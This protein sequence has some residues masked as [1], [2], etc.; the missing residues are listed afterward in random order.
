MY[1]FKAT[2]SKSFQLFQLG[3]QKQLLWTKQAPDLLLALSSNIR[4]NNN[5]GRIKRIKKNT[6]STTVLILK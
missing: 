6:R 3:K 5:P 1:F 2:L 4:P